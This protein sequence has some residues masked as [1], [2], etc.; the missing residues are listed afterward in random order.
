MVEQ[1]QFTVCF[2]KE[3]KENFE[4][5]KRPESFATYVKGAFY[6]RLTKDRIKMRD[7]E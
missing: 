5:L 4:E 1:K 3:D 2:N 7:K 6:H